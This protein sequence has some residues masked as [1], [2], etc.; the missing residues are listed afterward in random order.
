MDVYDL[1]VPSCRSIKL[2]QSSGRVTALRPLQDN[3]HLL[4]AS[5]D[6]LR[7]WSLQT[8]KFK[9]IQGAS[10]GYTSLGEFA[11]FRKGI[12][13]QGMLM[14]V[15]LSVFTVVDPR[16]QY[17]FAASGGRGWLE[18]GKEEVATFEISLEKE[19]NT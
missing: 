16:D 12:F 10:G 13:L 2:P 1:R 4:I 15:R 19:E 3:R 5:Q 18:N 7:L 11:P 9:I 14:S 17:L 6:T 8:G